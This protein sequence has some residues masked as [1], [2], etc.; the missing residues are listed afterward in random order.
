MTRVGGLTQELASAG[1]EPQLHQQDDVEVVC[2]RARGRRDALGASPSSF[3]SQK[4]SSSARPVLTA[5]GRLQAMNPYRTGKLVLFQ[6]SYDRGW[7]YFEIPMFIIIGV[8]GVRSSVAQTIMR[9]GE[10]TTERCLF[11]SIRASTAPSSSSTISRSHL[12]GASISPATASPRP[13]SSR[14][15]P[16]SSP[17]STNFSAS[18]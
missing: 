11:S 14:Q 16:R 18:T 12:S 4:A 1:D 15:R 10:L 5:R 2:L 6:V 9:P 13:S 8:F 17:T 3:R 7:H